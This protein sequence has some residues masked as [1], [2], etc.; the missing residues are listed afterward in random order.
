MST[1]LIERSS[2][3]YSIR[4]FISYPMWDAT[5]TLICRH[6]V[7]VVFHRI[8]GSNE[9]TPPTGQTEQTPI[10]SQES[11]IIPFVTIQPNHIDTVILYNI[12]IIGQI[13]TTIITIF[14]KKTINIYIID[15]DIFQEE[16]KKFSSLEI[17]S[18]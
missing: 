16:N 10:S 18:P 12:Y 2:Y 4:K 13:I 14:F 5:N 8:T 1:K 3:L 11:T 17:F 7:F 15:I 9:Q 6:N